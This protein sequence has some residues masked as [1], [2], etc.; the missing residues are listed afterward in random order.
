VPLPEMKFGDQTVHRPDEPLP[1]EMTEED[2]QRAI[3][4]WVEAAK[5][6]VNVA[7]FD[8]VEIHGASSSLQV[9][10]RL[11]LIYMSGI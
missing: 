6:A 2:I 11:F 3:R 9:S 8:G 10:D 5:K 1:V 7:G 4:D